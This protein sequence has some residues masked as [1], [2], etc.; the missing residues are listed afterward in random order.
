MDLPDEWR[1]GLCLWASGNDSVL[2]LWLFGSRA[3]GTA[4]ADSD[5]DIAITLMPKIGDT[6]W[7]LGN[8]FAL[9]RDWKR[10]LEAIV[11]RHVSLEN[12]LPQKSHAYFF[13]RETR[14][15]LAKRR[16]ADE[17]DAAQERGELSVKGQHGVHVPNKNMRATAADVGLSRKEPHEARLIRD[18]E[19]RDPGVAAHAKFLWR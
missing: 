16:L 19:K 2:Q 15:G 18:A 3:K 17:Y 13:G 5:I 8:Y 4:R 14:H 7:A 11:G 1:H 12:E 10:Q 9:H 6:D